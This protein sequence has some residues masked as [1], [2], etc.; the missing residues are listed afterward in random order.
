MA[1]DPGK[2]F[3]GMEAMQNNAGKRRN[4]WTCIS[5]LLK[6]LVEKERKDRVSRAKLPGERELW[7]PVWDESIKSCLC[8]CA[9]MYEFHLLCNC[10]Y[11]VRSQYIRDDNNF[12]HW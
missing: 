2:F 1:P 6:I 10:V 5:G 4:T 11:W 9:C 12:P 3:G 8:H 7:A